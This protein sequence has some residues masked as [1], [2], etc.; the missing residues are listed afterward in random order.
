LKSVPTITLPRRLL[1]EN[2][3]ANEVLSLARPMK[4][5]MVESS[6]YATTTTRASPRI[7]H[8]APLVSSALRRSAAKTPCLSTTT[9]GPAT[10]HIIP[11]MTP[12]TI[13]RIRPST[14][15][16]PTMMPTPMSGR[17]KRRPIDRHS[18][19][20]ARCPSLSA[21]VARVRAP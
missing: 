2:A 4:P 10:D 6:Q 17:K 1:T 19:K 13:S 14:T 21:T 3:P 16:M 5:R 15:P 18:P 12:G 7:F 8:R 9:A 11:R 20:L